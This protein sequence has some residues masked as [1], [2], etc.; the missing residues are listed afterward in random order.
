MREKTVCTIEA[1]M[2]SSRLPGKVLKPLVGQPMLAR[3]IERLRRATTLDDIVIAT[4]DHESCDPIESLAESLGVKCYRGSEDDVLKRVLDAATW[5]EA[6]VIVETTGDCPMIDPAVIDQV[7]LAY[8][9]SPIDYCANVLERTFPG[10]MD[11]QVFARSV[12]QRVDALTQDASDREHVSLYIYKHPE[13]FSLRNVRGTFPPGAENVRLVVD[14]P[15]DYLRAT[16]IYEALYPKNP[17]FSVQD[18][19]KFLQQNPDV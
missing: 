9:E 13:T 7:V 19:L 5:A 16:R 1:R 12:L 17:A 6:D 11:T 3:M 10:G 2:R 15:A 18:V 4:T 8:R 14:T